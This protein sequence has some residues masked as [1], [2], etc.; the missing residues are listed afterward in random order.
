[1]S[2]RQEPWPVPDTL[3]AAR[4]LYA[5][6]ESQKRDIDR[7]TRATAR[8]EQEKPPRL[9]RNEDWIRQAEAQYDAIVAEQKRLIARYGEAIKRAADLR[10][11]RGPR[12]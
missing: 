2:K 1:M 7:E 4:A 12:P 5:D 8:A 10:D 9:R 11:E 3:E 6:L